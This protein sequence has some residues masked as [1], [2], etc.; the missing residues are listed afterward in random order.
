MSEILSGIYFVILLDIMKS[1]YGE[2]AFSFSFWTSSTG[3]SSDSNPHFLQKHALFAQLVDTLVSESQ[4]G[5]C[6]APWKLTVDPCAPHTLRGFFPSP[7]PSHRISPDSTLQNSSLWDC[8]L[9][10][11]RSHDLSYQLLQH[12]G[13]AEDPRNMGTRAS[14]SW[15][16]TTYILTSF[17]KTCSHCSLLG[18]LFECKL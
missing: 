4:A 7:F 13:E 16:R 18:L 1:Q 10:S 6:L 5:N 9:F 2:P 3:V 8:Y 14:P 12:L 15:F 17:K 11:P